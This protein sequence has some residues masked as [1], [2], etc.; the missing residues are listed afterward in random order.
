MGT[1]G[2][3]ETQGRSKQ[4]SKQDAAA[5]QRRTAALLLL[6]REVDGDSTNGLIEE[7]KQKQQSSNSSNRIL[8]RAIH[9]ATQFQL[10]LQPR[11]KH[12]GV[13]KIIVVVVVSPQNNLTVF[14]M[15]CR[16]HHLPELELSTGHVREA[17]Q[18]VLH[19]ILFVRS[20]GPVAPRD[21][22]CEGFPTIIYP[23]IA[24]TDNSSTT[25][26]SGSS[27]NGGGAG[28][29]LPPGGGGGSSSGQQQ[30]QQHSPT[31]SSYSVEINVDRK[32][33]DAIESFLRSLTQIGPELL[34]VSGTRKVSGRRAWRVVVLCVCDAS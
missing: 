14:T 25:N 18:C 29:P 15:N 8:G 22:A 26:S 34:S 24:G 2:G 19:T 6:S 10:L 11:T 4:A 17:L 28:L 23:R 12:E 9:I 20:P 32:V 31:S 3:R 5:Q 1:T 7:K 27:N 13:E 30:Q 16:E 33:D 21:V